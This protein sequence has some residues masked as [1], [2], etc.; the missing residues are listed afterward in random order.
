MRGAI[1]DSIRRYLVEHDFDAFEP[2]LTEI[3]SRPSTGGRSLTH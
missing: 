2:Q 1:R 3:D